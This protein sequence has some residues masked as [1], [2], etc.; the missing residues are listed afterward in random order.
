MFIPLKPKNDTQHSQTSQSSKPLQ[1]IEHQLARDASFY[2]LFCVEASHPLQLCDIP[3]LQ[4]TH[5]TKAP[6]GILS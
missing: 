4:V 2:P 3:Y 5:T 6:L 1:K